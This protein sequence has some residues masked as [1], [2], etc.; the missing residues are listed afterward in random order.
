M[1]LDRSESTLRSK[2]RC[3]DRRSELSKIPRRHFLGLPLA[4]IIV[5][6]TV[7]AM[8]GSS[9]AGAA[10]SKPP[11]LIGMVASQS[12]PLSFIGYAEAAGVKAEIAILNKAGGVLGRK[13]EFKSLDDASS[14]QQ[15]VSATTALLTQNNVDLFINDSVYG[16]LQL[17]AA[18]KAGVLT[19]AVDD[20]PLD[21][22]S[23][24]TVFNAIPTTS[25]QVQPMLNYVAKTMHQTEVGILSTTDADGTG[26]TTSVQSLASKYH[27]KIA[28]AE[29]VPESATDVTSDLQQLRSAGAKVVVS[30]TPGPLVGSTLTDM[31]ELGW[32]APLVGLSDL[33]ATI[34]PGA[35]PAPT[36]KQVTAFS[37]ST[38][39]RTASGTYLGF[40]G[41]SDLVKQI[42]AD[43][44]GSAK[45]TTMPAAAYPADAL[46]LA[47]WAWQRA[48]TVNAA[49]AAKELNGMSKLSGSALPEL[50]SY[51]VGTN[52]KYTKSEHTM[53]QINVPTSAWTVIRQPNTVLNGTSIGKPL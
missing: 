53:A 7:A 48:G 12:G 32:T 19:V 37:I 31:N 20:A 9:G 33:A 42:D 10:S 21:A 28:S 6:A 15:A 22:S 34:P 13:L 11:I 27:I 26:F 49:A 44:D 52:L 17:P 24:P 29:A 14:A 4:A 38:G 46:R 30:W 1:V 8:A 50:Y 41:F 23:Y 36:L 43:G 16:A 25:Q 45:L 5:T 51:P 3:V 47:A 2:W 39:T 40:N 18:Q 35:A